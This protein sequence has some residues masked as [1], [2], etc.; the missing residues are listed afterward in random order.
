MENEIEPSFKVST[1]IWWNIT[2]KTFVFGIPL[3]FAGGFFGVILGLAVTG[4]NDSS[5]NTIASIC[6]ALAIIPV[7]IIVVKSCLNE[8]YGKYRV[9]ITE[10]NE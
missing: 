7:A 4:G 3:S 5:A 9:S 1:R 8:S 6:S 10:V 2:W